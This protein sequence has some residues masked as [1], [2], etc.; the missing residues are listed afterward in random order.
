MLEPDDDSALYYVNQLRAADP[1][2]AGL[3]QLSGAVQAQILDRARTAIDGGDYV[4][5]DTL[6][7]M[8]GTLGDSKDLNALRERIRVATLSA[9]NMPQEVAE[10]TLTRIKKLSVDYPERALSRQIE[11]EVEI[12]L[13]GHAEG[14]RHGPQGARFESAG[15]LRCGRHQRGFALALQ[16]RITERQSD[17]RRDEVARHISS[18]ELTAATSKEL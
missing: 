10:T 2:N 5:A 12:G 3:P 1:H 15:H 4:K 7:Q 17:L 14:H 9:G 18:F 16:A 6:L 8:A 11:G 13:Y